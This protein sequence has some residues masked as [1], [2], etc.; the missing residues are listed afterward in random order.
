MNIKQILKE[1]KQAQIMATLFNSLNRLEHSYQT[2]GMDTGKY[3]RER[4]KDAREF[5]H[6]LNGEVL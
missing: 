6:S 1:K 2:D 3:A 4:I 5:L